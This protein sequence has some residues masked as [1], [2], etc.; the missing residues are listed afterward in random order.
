MRG[1][2]VM[3]KMLIMPVDVFKVEGLSIYDQMVYMVIRSF[4]N[5]K[6]KIAFP[7]YDT[8]SKLGRMSRRK[9]IDCVKVLIEKGLLKKECRPSGNDKKD[10][11]SNVYQFP[12][13]HPASSKEHP[14][15]SDSECP[16]PKQKDFKPITKQMNHKDLPS[17]ILN[18]PKQEEQQEIKKEDSQYIAYLLEQLDNCNNQ[19]DKSA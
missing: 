1:V 7:S 9:A 15:S 5:G 10:H 12:S 14:A 8:I 11:S 13:E 16:A 4:M 18:Q 6:T 17:W 3:S 19:I 2:F